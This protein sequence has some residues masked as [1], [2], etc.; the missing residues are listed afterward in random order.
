MTKI[1][2][3]GVLGTSARFGIYELGSDPDLFAIACRGKSKSQGMLYIK[4]NRR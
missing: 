4:I 1:V 3:E 2:K